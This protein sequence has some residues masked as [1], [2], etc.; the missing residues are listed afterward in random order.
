[1]PCET[2]KLNRKLA[3]FS[4]CKFMQGRLKTTELPGRGS[5]KDVVWETKQL[6]DALSLQKYNNKLANTFESH[7]VDSWVLASSMVDHVDGHKKPDNKGLLL[8]TPLQ[9]HRRQLHLFQPGAGGIRRLYGGTRSLGF[10]RGSLVR[11][12]KHGVAYVGGSAKSRISLHSMTGT[13]STERRQIMLI[14]Y[15]EN[16]NAQC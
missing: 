13:K 8:L 12:P 15:G 10:Q 9:F 11:H 3:W 14:F 16:I 1:M 2:N 5:L 4:S 6:R 7:A